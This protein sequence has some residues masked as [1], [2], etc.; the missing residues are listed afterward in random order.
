MAEIL[1]KNAVNVKD[2][3]EALKIYDSLQGDVYKRQELG[4]SVGKLIRDM[5]T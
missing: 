3:R 5:R 2:Y 4:T 1:M